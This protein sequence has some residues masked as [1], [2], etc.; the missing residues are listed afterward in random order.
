MT[1]YQAPQILKLAAQGLAPVTLQLFNGIRPSKN[2]S[3]W[4]N[5]QLQ[6]YA[7]NL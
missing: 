3:L 1:Q 4:A 5:Q 7:L 2:F 6:E